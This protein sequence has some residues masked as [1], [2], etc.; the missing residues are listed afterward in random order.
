MS[1]CPIAVIAGQA[2]V[3]ACNKISATGD[4][5]G[6]VVEVVATGVPAGLGEPVFYKLDAELGKML[7]IGAVS[8]LRRQG[9]DRL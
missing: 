9:Y 8:R 3:D 7:G 2:M 4:S 5:A 1:V 6:G